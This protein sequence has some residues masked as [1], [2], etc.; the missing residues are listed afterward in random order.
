MEVLED[1]PEGVSFEHADQLM[2]G[3]ATLSPR[4]LDALLRE[5]RSVKAKRLF[6]WLADRQ[7]YP[8]LGK[9]KAS[10]YDLGSGKRVLIKGGR[11]DRTYQITVPS[12]FHGQE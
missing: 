10:D 7:K 5:V 12:E 1:V 3:L 8:W 4:R 9:L 2:Q 11:L 6:F